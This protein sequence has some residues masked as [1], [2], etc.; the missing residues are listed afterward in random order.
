MF[1]MTGSD[2]ATGS[3]ATG[4]DGA[5]A[6]GTSAAG[7]VGALCRAAS[8][9][10]MPCDA[11]DEVA[12][13]VADGVESSAPQPLRAKLDAIVAIATKAALATRLSL[14]IAASIFVKA[15][16]VSNPFKK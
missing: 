13:D 7:E 5:D 15:H 6:S 16:A 2:A 11:D 4:V 1:S 14:F 3:A 10:A 8:F 9:A 12:D